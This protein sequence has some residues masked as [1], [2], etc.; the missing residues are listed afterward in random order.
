MEKSSTQMGKNRTGMQSSPQMAELMQESIKTSGVRQEFDYRKLNGIRAAYYDDGTV[1]SVP[2]PLSAR[3]MAKAGTQMLKGNR[4]QAFIDKVGERLAFERTGVRLYEALINKCDQFEGL[5]LPRDQL[6]H[7]LKEEE[8]HFHMLKQ[9]LEDMGADP[10]AETPGADVAGVASQGLLKVI[11]DP[12]TS[13]AQSMEAMLIAELT[14][15]DSW[16]LL[17]ELAD[18]A[19]MKKLVKA[20][21][22]A[23]R[24]EDEHLEGI[25]SI[26]RQMSLEDESL[27]G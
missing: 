22:K 18:K 12:R 16:H 13:V 24:Q 14:D 17:T 23:S 5:D 19:G 21:E 15:N 7:Y 11:T 25:R 20:F 8:E 26:V 2:P 9:C 6:I 4:P 3:G 1:G 10:T 27:A